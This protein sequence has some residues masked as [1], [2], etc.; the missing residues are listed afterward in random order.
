MLFPFIITA[1]NLAVGQFYVPAQGNHI[2]LLLLHAVQWINK[3]HDGSNRFL[4]VEL[5]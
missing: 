3:V 2:G 1:R 5:M 4:A